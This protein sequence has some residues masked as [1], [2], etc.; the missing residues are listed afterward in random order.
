MSSEITANRIIE[1]FKQK[2]RDA[3]L[4]NIGQQFSGMSNNITQVYSG[5]PNNSTQTYS[6]MPNNSTQTYSGMPSN[7]NSSEKDLNTLKTMVEINNSLRSNIKLSLAI[8]NKL[9]NFPHN[10][11][12]ELYGQNSENS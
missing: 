3:Q 9:N 1:T 11:I 2:E 12:H 5:N 8:Y 6:G 4:S 7:Q 10:Y